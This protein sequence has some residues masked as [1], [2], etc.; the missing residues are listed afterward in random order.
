MRC[1]HRWFLRFLCPGCIS[2]VIVCRDVR[3]VVT[4]RKCSVFPVELRYV[5][6]SVWCADE[7]LNV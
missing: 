3:V 6:K 4:L 5:V 7:L 2:R 1:L